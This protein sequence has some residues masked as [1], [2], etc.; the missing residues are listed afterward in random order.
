MEGVDVR[1]TKRTFTPWIRPFTPQD[2]LFT[3][4]LLQ[5]VS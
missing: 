2:M 3:G 1:I 4:F 5:T